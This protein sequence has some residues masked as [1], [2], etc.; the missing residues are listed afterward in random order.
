MILTIFLLFGLANAQIPE[1]LTINKDFVP[2]IGLS[3]GK[4]FMLDGTAIVVHDGQ[5]TGYHVFKGML[6]YQKDTL[7]TKNPGRVL[8]N[9]QDDSQLTIGSQSQLTLNKI[10][11]MPR[12]KMRKSFISMRR[13]KARFNVRK[14]SKFNKTDYKVKTQ[15][16]LIGVR[17]SDFFVTA[18]RTSTSVTSFDN[19]KLAIIGLAKPQLPPTI[20]NDFQRVHVDSGDQPSDIEHVSPDEIQRI[21]TEIKPV[22]KDQTESDRKQE[23]DSDTDSKTEDGES[24]KTTDQQ[25][26]E[27]YSETASSSANQVEQQSS[28]ETKSEAPSSESP[29]Q[30]TVLIPTQEIVPPS[31]IEQAQPPNPDQIVTNASAENRQNK[32][33]DTSDEVQKIYEQLHENEVRLPSFPGTP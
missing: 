32:T 17:G 13:G 11:L 18:N 20:L 28:E 25:P 12:K 24:T 16:A 27:Q 5:N 8:L 10:R 6:L 30:E 9:M 14:L 26:D 23:T 4:V 15:T 3:I 31:S 2:G 21:K 33:D 7:Y 29:S 1:G 19:T 22:E